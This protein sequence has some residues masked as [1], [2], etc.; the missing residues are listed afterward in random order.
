MLLVFPFIRSKPA[1]IG[2][3]PFGA[4][5]GEPERGVGDVNQEWL[6]KFMK[7]QGLTSRLTT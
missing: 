1:D 7:E 3:R 2:I 5:S 4:A 6:Q